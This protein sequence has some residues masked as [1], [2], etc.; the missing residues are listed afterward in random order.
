MNGNAA[1][2]GHSCAHS[3]A[4][5]TTQLLQDC[6][7]LWSHTSRHS[8]SP[9]NTR[10]QSMTLGELLSGQHGD[11]GVMATGQPAHKQLLPVH[12]TWAPNLPMG[13]ILCR[14]KHGERKHLNG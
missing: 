1:T 11:I 8:S 7:D 3:L 4:A 9:E 13:A 6:C 2:V 5:Q 12:E 14:M 10:M